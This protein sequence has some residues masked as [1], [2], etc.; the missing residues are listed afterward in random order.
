MEVDRPGT[1][2]VHPIEWGV[3][4][5][6]DSQSVAV[7]IKAEILE[8]FD[9]EMK[10]WC[11]WRPYGM[12]ATGYFYV[13]KKD[14]SLNGQ[15]IKSLKQATGWNGTFSALAPESGT[16]LED[17]Q[18]TV[19]QDTYQG[20]TRFKPSWINSWDANPERGTVG[21][22]DPTKL[23]D[24]DNRFGGKIRAEIGNVARNGAPAGQ[25]AMPARM[26]AAPPLKSIREPVTQGAPEDD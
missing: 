11:D 8:Q 4:D 6:K 25:Q 23:R 26:A 1:F 18:F 17:C 12:E 24:L 19:V 15:Q 20:K 3:Q 16:V 2:R 21:T 10:E 7:V 9:D 22:A 14:G 13:I 5:G